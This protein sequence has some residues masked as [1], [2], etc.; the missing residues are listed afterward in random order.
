MPTDIHCGTSVWRIGINA[1]RSSTIVT[2]VTSVVRKTSLVRVAVIQTLGR[3]YNTPYI[4]S[5][6]VF[7]Q[8]MATAG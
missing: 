1:T 7:A 8:R 6:T 4:I 5:H 3:T 2:R